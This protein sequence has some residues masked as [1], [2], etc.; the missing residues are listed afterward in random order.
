MPKFQALPL[1]PTRFEP[2][3]ETRRS[4]APASSP[5][6]KRIQLRFLSKQDPLAANLQAPS[7]PKAGIGRMHQ[8][9]IIEDAA[10][11]IV[12]CEKRAVQ[13]D[14]IAELADDESRRHGN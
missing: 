6:E 12:L 14:E 11:D 9:S 8:A 2:G 5:R 13:I 7:P 1:A 3:L 10:L 4:S